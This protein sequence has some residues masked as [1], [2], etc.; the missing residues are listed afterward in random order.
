[1]FAGLPAEAQYGVPMAKGRPFL[2]SLVGLTPA[3]G[4]LFPCRTRARDPPN[5]PESNTAGMKTVTPAR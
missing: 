5:C 3:G 2:L 4:D 1:M